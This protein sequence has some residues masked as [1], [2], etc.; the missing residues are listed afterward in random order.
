MLLACSRHPCVPHGTHFC[1]ARAQGL[2]AVHEMPVECQDVR[3]SAGAVQNAGHLNKVGKWGE[4][5]RTRRA[6]VGDFNHG[7]R[8]GPYGVDGG[9]LQRLLMPTLP[10]PERLRLKRRARLLAFTVA[11]HCWPRRLEELRPQAEE[12]RKV[13][14][15]SPT[16]WR[17]GGNRGE[18]GW[19]DPR[20]QSDPALAKTPWWPFRFCVG[21]AVGLQ[22]LFLGPRNKPRKTGQG[23]P[24]HC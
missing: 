20:D 17:S 15:P 13:T 22:Q 6:G 12:S 18:S 11:S 10:A 8:E 19:L 5:Q 14:L 4:G 3:C 9:Y 1:A 24:S 2:A 7:R 16:P 23:R 21:A